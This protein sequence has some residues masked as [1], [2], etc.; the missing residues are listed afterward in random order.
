MLDHSDGRVPVHR[1][2][3]GAF[4]LGTGGVA[5]GV[6]HSVTVVA[7]LPGQL[8]IPGRV[9]VE[10][11]AELDQL[12][13]RGRAFGDQQPDRGLVAQTDAGAQR[14]AQVLFG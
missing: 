7:A 1:R 4:D 3:Q 8:E 2:D 9:A 6:D 14:V 5:A 13:D 12:L 10:A 11:G